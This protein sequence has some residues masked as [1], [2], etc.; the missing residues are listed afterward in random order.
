VAWLGFTDELRPH[1]D[2]A[3]RG[4]RDAGITLKVISGDNPETVAALARQAGLSG[5]ARLVSGIDLDRMGESEFLEAAE[6]ATVFGRVT[7][8]QKQR[9]VE[10]L[11][12]RGHYVAMT[13]DGVNDVLSLK[14]AN[15]GIAMQ[16]GSQATR[17]AADIVLLR[18]SF[19]ALPDAFR[20]GQRIR[21]S[22]CRILELFLSRV[23]AV[24][25]LI[26]GV[27]IVQAGFP[28]SP[29]QISLLTLLT[30]GIPTFGIALWTRPGPPPRSLPRRLLQFVL[31]ASMLL[32]FAAFVVY[33]G[34]YV[35]YDLALPTAGEGGVAAA[36]S[37]PARDFVSREAATH[38]LVLGGLL[39]VLFAAPP[40]PWFAVVEEMDGERRP[41]YLALAMAPLYAAIMATPMLRGFFGM[42]GIDGTAFGIVVIVV[43]IWMYVLRWVWATHAF[44]RFFGYAE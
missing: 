41:A 43:L 33:L 20:E 12:G 31:P 16:S 8:E 26:L 5:D 39:L 34:M 17:D 15:L 2:K 18:D 19:G 7:P 14:Q 25:L 28:L 11:R 44:E 10:A 1:V 38:V 6:Q 21:R 4:F 9:L 13:G 42:R 24:A 29:G 30:V 37:L 35:L 36:T 27:L 3:I 23:F 22:L 32:G 40:G